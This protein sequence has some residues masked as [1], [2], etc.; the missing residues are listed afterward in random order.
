MRG[1]S[2]SHPE[3]SAMPQRAVNLVLA[4][5]GVAAVAL[6]Y[7]IGADL[8][9]AAQRGP[10]WKRCLLSAGLA[11]LAAVGISATG[12]SAGGNAPAA[13]P[14]AGTAAAAADAAKDAPRVSP[15]ATTEYART[16]IRELEKRLA[17]L[18]KMEA[19][20][21]EVNPLWIDA[22]AT[23]TQVDVR[24]MNKNEFLSQVSDADLPHARAAIDRAAAVLKRLEAMWARPY[25][26]PES[27]RPASPESLAGKRLEETDAWKNLTAL[28]AFGGEIA[29]GRRGPFPFNTRQQE[30]LL[31][32]LQIVRKN[33]AAMENA[34][35]FSAAE[36]GLL[37][38]NLDAMIT[39]I[40]QFRP[41]ELRMATC[42]QPVRMVSPN[43]SVERL[44]ARLPLLEKLAASKTLHREVVEKVLVSIETDILTL[45]KEES[46]KEFAKAEERQKAEKTRDAAKA[47]AKRIRERIVPQRTCYYLVPVEP[48]KPAK[49]QSRAR[50]EA[51]EKFAAADTLRPDVLRQAAA[52]ARSPENKT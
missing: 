40:Q 10:R 52:N 21:D 14:E 19:G 7:V 45:S 48:A 3:E 17:H 32:D 46:L 16:R 6:L 25:Q 8:A 24:F 13:A 20:A 1:P 43:E 9:R 47:A 26:A 30:Q 39:R 11:L 37:G 27:P 34:G 50:Q 23:S 18:E 38:L 29:A 28:W 42:Y 51:L 15:A 31:A 22:L 4:L 5:A 36:A 35:L 49:E 41:E 33:V 12:C 44:A 2:K